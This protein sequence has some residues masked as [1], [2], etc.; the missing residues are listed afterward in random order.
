MA[1]NQTQPSSIRSASA[2]LIFI[3]AFVKN[4]LA[5]CLLKLDSTA[6]FFLCFHKLQK[7]HKIMQKEFK[8]PELYEIYDYDL[9][10]QFWN[11][12]YHDENFDG[13]IYFCGRN[14]NNK[15]YNMHFC[16]RHEVNEYLQH[17]Q[18]NKCLDYY[19]SINHFAKKKN[20]GI[21]RTAATVFAFCGT[22]I[23]LDIHNSKMTIVENKNRLNEYISKLDTAIVLGDAL[24]YNYLIRTGR[25]IQLVYIYNRAIP[26][27]LTIMHTRIQDII[28][29]QHEQIS[30]DFPN[31]GIKVDASSTRK[32][33]GVYRMPG[34]YHSKTHT[35]TTLEKTSFPY[36]DNSKIID[37]YGFFDEPPATYH[38][39]RKY[40]GSAPQCAKNRTIHCWKIIN[41]VKQYQEDRF[42]QHQH[43]GHENRNC[44]CFI[45]IH[46]L[47]EV[48]DYDE[49]FN[50]LKIFNN[51]FDVPLPEAKLK[52]MIDY[53]YNNYLDDSKSRMRHLKNTTVLEYLC[54]EEGDYGIDDATAR[55]KK[56]ENERRLRVEAKKQEWD[57]KNSSIV[58]LYYQGLNNAEIAKTVGCST[59]TVLRRIKTLIPEEDRKPAW[60]RQ[61]ISINEFYATIN[62]NKAKHK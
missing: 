1:T 30:N 5:I 31:L 2:L 42:A 21:R 3:F 45:Y 39:S 6:A 22:V 40:S 51:R 54:L 46:F 34:T 48:M 23:D 19:Y 12:I 43:P 27:T 9:C 24:P 55:R 17:L 41:A 47:L 52:F 35:F 29:K 33:S 53:A 36:L 37:T 4:S 14:R 16:A 26:S 25:G 18:I 20:K 60:E 32:K 13:I 7:G 28:I 44:T 58:E 15:F 10:K 62:Q 59:M 56:I 50:E 49:A 8:S 61:G 38:I 57:K 11:D